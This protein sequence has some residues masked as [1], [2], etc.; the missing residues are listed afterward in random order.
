MRISVSLNRAGPPCSGRSLSDRAAQIDRFLADA[1]WGEGQLAPL[2]GDASARRYCRLRQASGQTAVLMDAPASDQSSFQAFV[3]I[4]AHLRELGLSAPEIL[5]T[6]GAAGLILME[7][8]G[9]R[10]FAR[11]ITR[12]PVCEA[13][14]YERATDLIAFLR[15]AP[16]APGLRHYS[17]RQ[18]AGFTDLA[19]DYYHRVHSDVKTSILA[20]LETVLTAIEDQQTIMALRDY[21]A[22]NLIWLADREGLKSVGLLDFQDAMIAHPAYDLVSLLTD[23][24]RDVP[25]TLGEAMIA[26]Y[27]RRTGIDPAALAADA[28]I[29]GV[30]RNLRILGVFARL[31]LEHGRPGYIDLI[32]RVWR[33]LLRDLSHPGLSRLRALILDAFAEPGP[34]KLK[35]LKARC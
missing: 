35:E 15:D 16:P 18:L 8:L 19:M 27:A 12:A 21:H 25:Q 10:V 7:D 20:E 31:A 14:L 28:A 24:R 32:P 22:E 29:I 9:D 2:A 34:G 3:T 4:G 26:R 33:Y 6:D 1:G 30:Q 13:A 23:A 5:A 11:E 17:A